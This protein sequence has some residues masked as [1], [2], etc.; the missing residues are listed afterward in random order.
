MVVCVIRETSRVQRSESSV[1]SPESSVQ[2]PESSV[3]R[4]TFSV[5]LLRAESRNSG[6]PMS[7]AISAVFISGFQQVFIFKEMTYVKVRNLYKWRKYTLQ[8]FFS[9]VATRGVLF[10]GCSCLF[11]E[12]VVITNS[13]VKFSTDFHNYTELNGLVNS[14]S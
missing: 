12:W 11:N 6:M 2:S 7:L 8:I 5:Q 4:P 10:G 1:Q 3:Q 9:E 13:W 14:S